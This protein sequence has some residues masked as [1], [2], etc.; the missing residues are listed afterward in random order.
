MLIGA[1]L[2]G[3]FPQVYAIFL[4]AFYLPVLL[5]LLA[6]IFR[7]VAFEFRYR[8]TRMRPLWDRGFALGSTVAAFVQGAAIGAMISEIP[9]VDG[10]FAGS[11]LALAVAVRAPVR[12]RPG[13]GLRAPGSRLDRPQGRRP[14]ARVGLP[15]DRLAPA[16]HARRRGG[17]VPAHPGPPAARVRRLGR[18]PLVADLPGAG[19][20]G[21]RRRPGGHAPASRRA[22]VPRHRRPVRRGLPVPRGQLLALHDPLHGDDRERP[23]LRSRR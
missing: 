19:G 23:P 15:A 6:L 1:A 10:R 8:T 14:A 5:L 22:A 13:P 7:G 9:V 20:A 16:G 11:A 4:P 3:A 12:R 17:R 2:F 18:P 21:G